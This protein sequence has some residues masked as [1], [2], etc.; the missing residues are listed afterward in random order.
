MPSGSSVTSYHH[1]EGDSWERQ[2]IVVSHSKA[3]LLTGDEDAVA[4]CPS[5]LQP[6]GGQRD[7]RTREMRSCELFPSPGHVPLVVYLRLRSLPEGA[8]SISLTRFRM[9]FRFGLRR[10]N[11]LWASKWRTGS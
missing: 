4:D 1:A 10:N 2:R 8:S 6:Q 3:V 7:R 9:S 5:R 11:G